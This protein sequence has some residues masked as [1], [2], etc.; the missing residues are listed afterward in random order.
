MA[1][2]HEEEA[3][4]ICKIPLSRRSVSDS[5]IWLHNNNAKFTVKS[6][7]RVAQQVLKDGRGA[8]SS[9][10]SYGKRVWAALWNKGC[11]DQYDLLH[12]LECLLDR[13]S[14]EEVEVFFTQACFIWSRRNSVLHG[15]RFIDPGT[16]NRRA[17]E[18]LQEY[19]H[20][21]E[22]LDAEPVMNSMEAW[23]PP[24]E[25]AFKL[26]FDAE[27]FSEVNR[28]GVGAIIRNYK[29]EV[30]VAMSARVPAVHSSE[31]GELLACRKAI[32]FAIDAGFSS[33]EDIKHLI[34][35]L[36]WV[37][38]SH[39]RQSGNKVAHVLVQHA[40][41]IVEYLY[42]IEDSPPPVIEQLYQE[43]FLL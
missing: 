26:N 29:G 5:I 21:Q 10:G 2:F 41:I 33:Q 8:E 39:I 3:D 11:T 6:A 43:V 42:W 40:R 35:G 15:G 13:L 23:E 16:L 19:K 22:Q 34:R 31:E 27:V 24:P 14:L 1:L 12:L 38:T 28:A 32:E 7:Y 25:S 18:Y 17:A 36:Q 9:N 4:A 30:M 37:S 20:A